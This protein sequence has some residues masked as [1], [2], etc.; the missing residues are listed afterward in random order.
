[1]SHAD[2]K[3]KRRC[4]IE[5]IIYGQNFLTVKLLRSPRPVSSS[6]MR[7]LVNSLTRKNYYF[8]NNF[9]LI[10]LFNIHLVVTDFHLL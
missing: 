9:Q 7:N 4:L 5:V 3:K 6:E 10:F 8:V 1:M 2:V